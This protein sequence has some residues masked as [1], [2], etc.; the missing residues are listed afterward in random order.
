MD[1]LRL[2]KWLWAA[3]FYKTRSLAAQEI[4]KAR[5]EVNGLAAKPARELSVG[6][7]V[8]L[9]KEQPAMLVKVIALSAV[10]GPATVARLLYEETPDSVAAR[11]H[12]AEQRRLAPE[13][14]LAHTEGR[15]TK[16]DR[17]ELERARGR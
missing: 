4:N 9:K 6:D 5:V 3:R 7:L 16:R 1:R 13:P 2:D 11:A 12:A 14:A 8:R 15:P 10:R 17:R